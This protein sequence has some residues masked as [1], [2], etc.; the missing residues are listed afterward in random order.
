[1][2]LKQDRDTNLALDDKTWGA[3]SELRAREPWRISVRANSRKRRS[4][5]TADGRLV[6]LAADHYARGVL[7]IRD[8]TLAMGNRQD[9][10]GRIVSA[11]GGGLDGLMAPPDVLEDLLA[12]EAVTEEYVTDDRL[13]IGCMQRGGLA[14][15][16]WEIDDRF[17]SYTAE[18]LEK[19]GADGG[20]MMVRI[21]LD[22]AGTLSTLVGC[23]R[24][25]DELVAHDLLVFLEPM[26][27]MRVEQGY[28][29]SLEADQLVRDIG[30]CQAL[31]SS[32]QKTWLKV[33]F[34]EEFE[35]VARA[36]TLPLL[37]LGGEAAGSP[38]RLFDELGS[39]M[40][41]GPNVR[42]ALVGRN[43]LYP[44]NTYDPAEL[45]ADVMSIVHDASE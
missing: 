5:P 43:V 17:T 44:G 40:A 10:L 21:Q 37:L 27:T 16:V 12:Y 39:A 34:V 36:T 38:E 20:K 29:P 26:P 32:T 4:Q 7:R 31:G 19:I 22:D 3:I 33:P 8:D 41:A 18:S 2:T 6:V 13:L 1:M 30:I 11:M 14:N 24:A 15:A 35:K 45:A 23:A 28:Q 9:L 42:G 25:I